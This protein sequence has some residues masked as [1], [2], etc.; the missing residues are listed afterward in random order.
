MFL[1][2]VA[3][4]LL[5]AT[6]FP[7]AKA[8]TLPPGFTDS[9]VI[10]GLELP[11]GFRFAPDGRV[12][13]I[14]KSGLVK[15]FDSLADTDAT[16]VTDFRTEV[17]NWWDRGMLGLAI[18]PDF[19]LERPYLYLLYTYDAPIGGT[20]PTWGNPGETSD[21]CPTPP[22]GLTDGCLASGRL[23]R[24]EV[25]LDNVMVGEELVLINDW[26]IQFN[27]HTIGTVTFGTDRALYAGGGEGAAYTT[28]DY[29]Q[30]GG[31]LE[32]TPTPRNPCGDPPGGVGGEMSPPTAEGGSLRSQDLRTGDD[33]A[34]LDGSIIRV[35][36]DTG[37]AQPDNPFA[38]DPDPN[39]QKI[40]AYGLRN[41]YRWTFRPETTEIWIGDV[42]QANWEEINLIES[43]DDEVVENFGWPCYEGNGRLSGFDNLNLD[44]CEDLYDEVGAATSPYFTY[45]HSSRV[46]PGEACPTGSSA[47]SGMAFYEGGRYP[48]SYDGALFFADYARNCIW[49]MLPGA[50]GRPDPERIET[51]A[52]GASGPVDLQIG[53]GGD[54]FYADIINGEI[55]RISYESDVI[56]VSFQK[57]DG[58]GHSE[59]DDAFVYSGAPDTNYGTNTKL[60]VDG[61]DC[62][63]ALTVCKTL[64]MFPDAIGGEADQ[65]PRDASIRTATLELTVTN[66]GGLQEVFQ[67]T[68]A[69]GESTVTWNSFANPG[70]PG[71]KP[72]ATSFTPP[73]G[74]VAVDITGIVQNWANGEANLGILI[75]SMSTNG[76]DFDS[77]EWAT[78]ADRPRLT[79][80]FVPPDD[81]GGP[82]I[83]PSTT[84]M[85]PTADLTW[86]V[87]DAVG[88]EGSAVDPEDGELPSSALTW[89][90]F[91]EHCDR[92]DPPSCHTHQVQTF[93]GVASGSFT[94]PD[95]EYPSSI[96]VR[97]TAV[98]SGGATDAETVRVRPQTV[99]IT[100]ESRPSGLQLSLNFETATAPFVRTVIAGSA[101]TIS[102]PDPQRLG[103][104]T[105]VFASW[106]DG[107]AQTHTITA[108]T[109]ATYT[110]TY[111]AAEES[112]IG[113]TAILDSVLNVFDGYKWGNR[114]PLSEEG[115]FT[116]VSAYLDGLGP[117]SG[118]QA[119]LALIYADSAG[120]PDALR[121]TSD[122]VTIS[123]GQPAG[124][125]EFPISPAV[126]LS[127][128]DYWL[129]LHAGSTS[130]AARRYGIA[131]TGFERY[132][133]DAYSDGPSDPFGTTITGDWRWSLFATYTPGSEGL[134][135]VSFQK[136]DGGAHSETDD[137]YIYNGAP[138]TNYGTDAKLFVDGSGC[139]ATGT[140]CKSLIKFPDIIG[141]ATGQVPLG[142]TV[143]EAV[144]EITVT[145]AGGLQEVYQVTEGWEE[146]TATWNGFATPGSPG[147]K[148]RATSFTPP[149]GRI[150]VDI[151]AVVQAWA[152]DEPN[153][154]ILIA[155][156]SSN[157]ADYDS[158]E[159]ATPPKLTVTY[160]PPS[161]PG[162]VDRSQDQD[163]AA[164]TP[165]HRTEG[166]SGRQ[167]GTSPLAFERGYRA[168]RIAG[169]SRC[170]F[171]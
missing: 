4:V 168:G 146:P 6:L 110:A 15:E 16:I 133:A 17:H 65:V 135:T 36:P 45:G 59:T 144:L 30:L 108:S 143:N 153:H 47:I 54:L 70:S 51:F 32:G 44:M 97:L 56:T 82:N 167:P 103:S 131:E 57:E 150:R 160:V 77:S 8:S 122:A 147:V 123:D 10:S 43:V 63:A 61:R 19:M 64:I 170:V 94:A 58:G 1:V 132:N 121:A 156:T 115:T 49:A 50:D 159:S 95:H 27:T 107:G 28:P 158:S 79:V 42:G 102:A 29:G 84:I 23:S 89:D 169:V 124:W 66:A 37:A 73:V 140:V 40:I 71:T 24:I 134:V 96:L 92:N 130:Q 137:A 148:G 141:D 105:Y 166:G 164:D 52:A 68:E 117:G 127:P 157:G 26:C 31:S 46:V 33:P 60:Y 78:L 91:V 55:H 83:P 87:G 128:G 76:A 93:D 155:S 48:D 126:A 21:G 142:S 34:T 125:V 74:R 90:I 119:L 163:L 120:V 111:E 38:G 116:K 162:S 151:T 99:D 101:N 72:L 41:P 138:D 75:A 9:A 3:P 145:N 13:I 35:D 14:E 7:A 39:V 165:D 106:S 86:S 67:L 20:A 98:D 18:D 100:L 85:Q 62:I 152:N 112:T 2:L 53:P 113:T 80:T 118:G 88:F 171:F 149:V 5:V 109:P 11:T 69:W 22:G 104:S 25:G 129:V 161:E 81:G 12:F 114:Y 136:G 139:I 154:G